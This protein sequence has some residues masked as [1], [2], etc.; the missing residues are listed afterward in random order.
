SSSVPK[1]S[2]NSTTIINPKMVLFIVHRLRL[3]HGGTQP[4]YQP[5]Q[6]GL[7][8]PLTQPVRQA[9]LMPLLQLHRGFY[10]NVEAPFWPYQALLYTLR[11][12]EERRVGKECS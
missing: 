2:A 11:R 8:L 10:K 7:L 6:E 9:F 4:L 3:Q 1:P 5:S 12:S